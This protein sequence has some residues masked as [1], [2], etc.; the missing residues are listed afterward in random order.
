MLVD[1]HCHLDRLELDIFDGSLSKALDAAR[2]NGVEEF[3]C[4]SINS[5]NHQLVLEIADSYEDV[6]AS[7][8][9]HPL[10][11]KGEEIDVDKLVST[12]KHSKVI[13]IGET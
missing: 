2:L 12:A 11:S 8:G 5:S 4:I 1:S 7:I 3:L 6:Y 9:I 13:A 10:Y